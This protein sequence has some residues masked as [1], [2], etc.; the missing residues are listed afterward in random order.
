MS[1][2]AGEI[3]RLNCCLIR[4]GIEVKAILTPDPRGDAR[5]ILSNNFFVSRKQNHLMTRVRKVP[6]NYVGAVYR[7]QSSEGR[8]DDYR[9]A[10]TRCA[11]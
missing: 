9:Q 4:Q 6:F 5:R 8:I 2:L 11:R 1:G 7:V 3:T 10:T